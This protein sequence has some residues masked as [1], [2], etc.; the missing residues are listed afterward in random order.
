MANRWFNQFQRVLD[1]EVV[2]VLCKVTFGATGA[3]TIAAASS[4]GVVSVTR[5]AQG[6]FTFVFG[7]SSSSLDT[8]KNLA[9][10]SVVYNT[11]AVGASTAAAAP[12]LQVVGD[13]IATSGTASV[14]LM[15]TNTS[16]SAT[17]PASGELGLFKFVFR[18]SDAF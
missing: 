7:T 18:N 3:P 14:K 16:G 6:N 15:T 17:D 8:Y 9:S 12:G 5:N 4:K 2:T 13:S 11:V 1:K 10:V